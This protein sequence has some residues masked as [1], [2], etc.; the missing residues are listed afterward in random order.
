M[1]A[2]RTGYGLKSEERRLEA[3]IARK[4]QL[5]AA[6]RASRLGEPARR[7][8]DAS[9]GLRRFRAGSYFSFLLGSI[10]DT[11]A[12]G[13]WERVLMLARRFRLISTVVTVTG[14]VF[15]MLRTGAVFILISGIILTLLPLLAL[16]GALALLYALLTRRRTA[17][18]FLAS[19]AGRPLTVFYISRS[20]GC[21]GAVLEATARQIAHD[22]G[23]VMIVEPVFRRGRRKSSAAHINRVTRSTFFYLKRLLPRDGGRTDVYL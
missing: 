3:E 21:G 4:K 7:A 20:S 12:Y 14:T 1:P 5:L 8:A 22:G 19:R 2:K 18:R 9:A 11:V 15:A 23:E 10:R 17:R 16:F 13:L 6:L